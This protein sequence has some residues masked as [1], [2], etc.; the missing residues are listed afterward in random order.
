MVSLVELLVTPHSHVHLPILITIGLSVYRS[1]EV[2]V[3][4]SRVVRYP[5]LLA[6]CDCILHLRVS[7]SKVGVSP[8]AAKE[9]QCLLD[10][11]GPAVPEKMAVGFET[12]L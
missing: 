9:V 5:Y 7:L 1:E 6:A 2:D 11:V 12:T 8:P 3:V 4:L 10:L